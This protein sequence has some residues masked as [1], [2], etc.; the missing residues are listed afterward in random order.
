MTLEPESYPT[1]FTT[2][3]AIVDA[4]GRPIAVQPTA[5]PVAP[6]APAVETV[7]VPQ[8]TVHQSVATS[9][10]RRYAFDSV[11]VGLIGLAYLI[12][13]LIAMTR[14]GF[15]G[16]MREPVVQVAGFSHTATLGIIDAA[17]G[18][19]LLLCAATLTRG[20]SVFFGLL[21]GV[22]GVVGAVQTDSFRRSLA[23]ESGFAWLAVV[24]AVIIVLVSLLV[25]RMVTRT[26]RVEA[27]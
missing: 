26:D 9:Y 2:D 24:A 13:G 20:G 1:T 19:A 11:V 16:S 6:V 27:I 8:A 3:Q 12:V 23:L 4:G 14:A 25:P 5:V 7:Y 15:D 21:L 18:L 10:G 22:A 17:V